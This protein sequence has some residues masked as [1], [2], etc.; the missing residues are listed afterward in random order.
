VA[1]PGALFA[2]LEDFQAAWNAAA[3]GSS[4]G[5]ITSWTPID[6]NG[7]QADMADIG[8]NLRVGA[9][10]RGSS[11]AVTQVALGWLPLA[12]DAQQPAQNAAFNN[13]FAI[14]VR[15]VNPGATAGDQSALASNLGISSTQPP[16]PTGTS[17]TANLGPERYLLEAVDVPG[18][19]GPVTIVGARLNLGR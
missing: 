16:F 1:P 19:D 6:V 3:Q 12:D 8:G 14:L 17:T 13:A 2:S 10:L 7:T 4:V 18:Q 9:V 5:Q 15:T 11:G